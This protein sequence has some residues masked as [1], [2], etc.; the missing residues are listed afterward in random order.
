MK[1]CSKSLYS[2]YIQGDPKFSPLSAPRS[3]VFKKKMTNEF[4]NKTYS[5]IIWR[6]STFGIEY[7]RQT[8]SFAKIDSVSIFEPPAAWSDLKLGSVLTKTF[9]I[10]TQASDF[11]DFDFFP[12]NGDLEVI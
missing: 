9:D 10:Y 1:I 11:S 5:K 2:V 6:V 4:S 7:L 3:K 8:E 12:F